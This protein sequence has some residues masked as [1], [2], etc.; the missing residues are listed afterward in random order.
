VGDLQRL[1]G[2]ME[3]VN[4]EL[5]KMEYPDFAKAM[6][7]EEL[8]PLVKE[9][10]EKEARV[11]SRGDKTLQETLQALRE[12]N[13]TLDQISQKVGVTNSTVRMALLGRRLN[14]TSR[15]K[16]AR[17]FEL[18][19]VEPKVARG[20]PPSKRPDKKAEYNRRYRERLQSSEALQTFATTLTKLRQASGMTQKELEKKSQV[21][22]SRIENRCTVP[23]LAG[24]EKIADALRVSTSVFPDLAE[25]RSVDYRNLRHRASV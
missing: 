17:A 22:I 12:D 25:L 14:A 9:K 8:W 2:L 10:P 24:I 19:M 21:N 16:F 5:A 18:K 13:W 11:E 7:A 1:S 4:R 6:L 23:T 3:H 20:I 15:R